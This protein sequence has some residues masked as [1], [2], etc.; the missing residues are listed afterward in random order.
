MSQA[1]I[2]CVEDEVEIREM[3]VEE[4]GFAGYTVLQAGDGVEAL[5]LFEAHHPD[6]VITDVG[7]PRMN[8]FELLAAV[9][10]RK[11]GLEDT[12][13]VMLTALADRQ[14]QIQGRT[15]GADDYLTKPVD[16]DLLLATV[17]ARL[18][19]RARQ[20]GAVQSIAGPAPSGILDRLAA[21]A[22]QQQ[23]TRLTLVK[24]DS[25][26]VLSLRMDA[27]AR[28]ALQRQVEQH[29]QGLAEEGSVSLYG[30]GLWALIERA[31]VPGD[32][33]RCYRERQPVEGAALAMPF[34][35]SVLSIDLDWRN[36]VLTRLAPPALM[37]SLALNLTFESLQQ[38]R[39]RLS[40]G[41][42]AYQLLES[43]RFAE[44]NLPEAIRSGALQLVFQPRVRLADRR[45]VGAEALLR[46]PGAS[47]GALSPGCFV[48]AAER[49]GYAALL[50]RWVID[51]LLRAMQQ[52]FAS[53]PDCVVSFNL[54]AASLDS[55]VPRYL[56]TQ[57]DAL[58]PE[59]ARRLE[60]EI[61]ETSMARLDDDILDAIDRL[62]RQGMRLAVDDFGVGYASLTYLK[63]FRTEV[64]K[65]DRS[66]VTGLAEEGIDRHIVEGLVGLARGLGCEV[67][68]EG[69][70]TADQARILAQLGCHQAQGYYFYQPMPL[71]DFRQ[72]LE[73][74]P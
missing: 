15:L 4:L 7:M 56:L 32:A 20:A 46:W 59:R 63:Q 45:V 61:T 39:R 42:E 65:I 54:S 68:A 38:P 28:S 27:A 74:Q 11:D 2:L 67:V 40:L 58:G 8:G 31:D 34:T 5:A 26:L 50:D 72:L 49:A 24:I 36:P 35:A 64:I 29:L 12:P 16:F 30:E 33:Y 69:V 41:P 1:T 14:N 60:M 6:L 19:K 73:S 37:E 71:A 66:F 43:V 70:E 21:C 23:P 18:A 55:D 25:Y 52:L 62:R 3:I 44:H 13:F 10:G 17:A 57:L 47:I 48:P 53:A 22:R 51:S 9:T